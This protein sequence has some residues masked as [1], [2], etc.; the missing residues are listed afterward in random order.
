MT[1]EPMPVFITTRE[2]GVLAL[3]ADEYGLN[4]ALIWPSYRAICS[5]SWT[6]IWPLIHALRAF[7]TYW[8]TPREE[9][10]GYREQ[11]E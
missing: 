6:E 8:N 10:L 9:F 5:L 7:N 4:I 2:H 1:N 11:P 3:D